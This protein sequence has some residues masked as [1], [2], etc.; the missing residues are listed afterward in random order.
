MNPIEHDTLLALVDLL[1][2]LRESEELQAVDLHTWSVACFMF[3]T[4]LHAEANPKID[5]VLRQIGSLQSGEEEV[6]S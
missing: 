5:R 4:D 2:N 1:H 3:L 6:S